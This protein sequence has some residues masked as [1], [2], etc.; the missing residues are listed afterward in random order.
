MARGTIH[1]GRAEVQARQ[2]RVAQ[3]DSP[4]WGWAPET[5]AKDL[6]LEEALNELVEPTTRGDPSPLRWTCKS[7]TVWPERRKLATD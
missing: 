1:A 6:E 7:T 5:T 3:A 2:T 4:R